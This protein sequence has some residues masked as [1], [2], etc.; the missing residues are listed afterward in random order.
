MERITDT[1]FRLLES[2]DLGFKRYLTHRI[3]WDQRLIALVGARGTGKTT[4]MLQHIKESLPVDRTLYVSADNI[5]FTHEGLLDLADQFWKLGGRHLFIDEVHKYPNW[6]Q[7]VKNIYDSF[8]QLQVVLTGSSV[9]DMLK[10]YGDLSRRAVIH[11][12]RGLSLREYI[13]MKHGTELPVVSLDDITDGAPIGMK[14]LL[15]IKLFHEYLAEGHYP[16]FAEG[17]VMLRLN[18]AV[19]AVFEVDLPKHL[20]IRPSSID[21]LKH[22]LVIIAGSVPFKPNLSKLA[23][24]TGISRN[25]LPDHLHH[26]ERA[27]LIAQLRSGTGGIRSLGKAD[28]VYL[29]NTTLMHM[30]SDRPDIGTMRETFF[31]NQVSAMHTVNA[32]DRVDFRVGELQFEVGGRKKG[33]HQLEGLSNAFLV[34]DD[35]E[36]PVGNT[37]PLWHFGFLY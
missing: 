35:I 3:N 34:K 11:H 16:F 32:S 5:H 2:T 25:T 27:G 17:D 14:G 6:S 9:I 7:E 19:N 12:L 22:L 13:S 8:P 30:F 20:D 28:K 1:Y 4:L 26:L 15:P 36:H 24:M 10:G 29:D 37:I 23:E 31:L 33:S 18:G 21:K